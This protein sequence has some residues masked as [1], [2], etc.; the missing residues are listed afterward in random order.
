MDM[1][2]ILFAG[3]EKEPI[4]FITEYRRTHDLEQSITGTL[5]LSKWD[6]G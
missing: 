6:M 3:E 2:A 5:M 4:A 1:N